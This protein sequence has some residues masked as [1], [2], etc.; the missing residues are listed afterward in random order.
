MDDLNAEKVSETIQKQN[1]A[2]H[3]D[4]RITRWLHSSSSANPNYLDRFQLHGARGES[5]DITS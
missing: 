5:M 2:N 4:N 1:K 3:S